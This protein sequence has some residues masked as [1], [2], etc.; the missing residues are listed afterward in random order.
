MVRD[1]IRKLFQPS[2]RYSVITLVITGFLIGS[3]TFIGSAVM[4]S[5]TGTVDF[6]LSCH[7][8]QTPY[9]EYVQS[10]HSENRTGVVATCADCHLPH[11]YPEKLFVKASRITEVW[12]LLTGVID[13]PEKYEKMRLTMARNVWEEFEGNDSAP[14]RGCHEIDKMDS[15]KQSEHAVKAHRRAKKNNTTCVTCHLGIAHKLPKQPLPVAAQPKLEG[16]A[17]NCHGCHEN[18]RKIL[19]DSH[20]VI[21]KAS[22]RKCV[23]C[24]VPGSLP[25]DK[26]NK[27][28]T[29]MHRAHQP[30]IECTGCHKVS[31]S[32]FSLLAGNGK[33]PPDHAGN[34]QRD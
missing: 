26:S 16:E 25:L 10:N 1:F 3:A 9:D 24:H 8:M 13:T 12:S 7:V 20:P 11:D 22:L 32:G 33:G 27:F 14:C 15:D 2:A 23:K 19:P 34:N 6:C 30:R 21:E 18:F 28:Y 29:Y 4:I 31:D 5:A 17:V